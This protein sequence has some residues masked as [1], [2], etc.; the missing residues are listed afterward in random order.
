MS[1]KSPDHPGFIETVM[2]KYLKVEDR[3]IISRARDAYAAYRLEH[4]Y[5]VFPKGSFKGAGPALAYRSVEIWPTGSGYRTDLLALSDDGLLCTASTVSKDRLEPEQTRDLNIDLNASIDGFSR[6]VPHLS[7]FSGNSARISQNTASGVLKTIVKVLESSDPQATGLSR[8]GV[9]ALYDM[10][11]GRFVKEKI[12]QSELSEDEARRLWRTSTTVFAINRGMET[13]RLAGA[14]KKFSEH[15]DAPALKTM[16]RAGWSSPAD[17]NWVMGDGDPIRKRNRGQALELYPLFADILRNDPSLVREVDAGK[18]VPALLSEK[19]KIPQNTLERLRGVSWQKLGGKEMLRNP[20]DHEKKYGVAGTSLFV[21]AVASVPKEWLPKSRPEWQAFAKVVR[22]IDDFQTVVA[23]DETIDSRKIAPRDEDWARRLR[24]C[25]PDWRKSAQAFEK[26]PAQGINDLNVAVLKRVAVP[27]LAQAAHDRGVQ[28]THAQVI[29]FVTGFN[30][31]TGS[32]TGASR[33]SLDAIAGSRSVGQILASSEKWHHS[34]GY[35]NKE[36]VTFHDDKDDIVWTA[37][38]DDFT[39]RNG[40][41]IRI[42]TSEN[43][44]IR[45][46]LRMSHCADGY[47]ENCLENSIVGTIEDKRGN[48]VA[49][50]ELTGEKVQDLAEVQL[51]GPGNTAPDDAARRALNEYK[52]ALSSGRLEAR[53]EELQRSRA[54][55][56]EKLA[57]T[58]EKR[59]ERLVGYDPLDREKFEKAVSLYTPYLAKPFQKGSTSERVEKIG[60]DQMAA[61]YLDRLERTAKTVSQMLQD[62]RRIDEVRSN[63]FAYQKDST[64]DRSVVEYFT[65]D[66]AGTLSDLNNIV[67]TFDESAEVA[68]RKAAREQSMKNTDLGELSDIFNRLDF[69]ALDPVIAAASSAAGRGDAGRGSNVGIMERD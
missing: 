9:R 38:T 26:N 66:R 48:S 32:L 6:Q 64:T 35:L 16:R 29:E 68:Q 21:Q 17:Y 10:S 33:K 27:V 52:A 2:S 44:L 34:R 65:K 25:G 46:G 60:I 4:S 61:D 37:L 20:G 50:F 15:L 42:I 8:K 40:L 43:D 7:A 57:P 49:T 12:G 23:R 53:F 36:I 63:I 41:K 28:L 13:R 56:W 62:P 51:Y 11:E 30:E 59:I 55:A 5:R 1:N 3:D 39:A 47:V 69:R 54:V 45:E 31:H 58:D 22:Q 24:E 67:R 14:L 18:S 19:F